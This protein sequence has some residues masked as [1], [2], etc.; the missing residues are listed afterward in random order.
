MDLKQFISQSASQIEPDLI[1]IFNQKV[2]GIEGLIPLTLGEPDFNTPT[3]IKEA[4]IQAI[5][6]NESHYTNPRG[7]MEFRTA[8][9]N[10]VHDKY[11]VSYDPATEVLATS[12]VSEA[13]LTT[14]LAILNAGDE[15]I[16]PT[17]AFPVYEGVVKIPG[18]KPVFVDT[19]DDNFKLTPD[20][21]EQTLKAHSHV[22]ALI[23]NYPNNP[24]GATY[25]QSELSA[26]ADVIKQHDILLISD[27]IYSEL[28]Y[29]GAHFSIAKL[30]PEQTIM[31][32]GLSKSHAM[33][34]WRVG[35]VFAK[36]AILNEIF[37]MHVFASFSVNTIAQYA[38][39]EAFNNGRDD[40]AP[41]KDIYKQRRDIVV[42]GLN[43][44]GIATPNPS[45]AFYIFATI[46][47]TFNGDSMQFCLDLA[48]QA[49]VG[50]VPGVG[51]GPGGER[52]FRLSY[53]ASTEDLKEAVSR[54]QKFMKN[55][56]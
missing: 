44:V 29:G 38:A 8:A 55:I 25:D 47:D 26:L 2:S 5:E 16:I 14:F 4:A 11:D 43:E 28:T 40:A 9:A 31:Y 41:M 48:Q 45:G 23:L 42:A 32:N 1:S 54:I 17:P 18:G 34:G 37:K 49:K 27:E 7:L 12:G 46:P 19:S 20:K 13:L 24:T 50:V 6:Q 35:V 21:L 3:H 56:K 22:K 36:P 53:A 51:F 30:L 52:S 39:I 10:Y 15:V 33:T